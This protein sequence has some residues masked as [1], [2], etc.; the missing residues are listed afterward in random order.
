MK[1]KTMKITELETFTTFF[2]GLDVTFKLPYTEDGGYFFLMNI[3]SEGS[4]T[5]LMENGDSIIDQNWELKDEYYDEEVGDQIFV[6]EIWANP[7]A[8]ENYPGSVDYHHQG[9]TIHISLGLFANIVFQLYDNIDPRKTFH[10]DKFKKADV[11]GKYVEDI[12]H[13]IMQRNT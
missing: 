10:I 2:S 5:G 8:N 13:T 6:F 9:S 11:I 1:I 3:R 7:N 12:V 4:K